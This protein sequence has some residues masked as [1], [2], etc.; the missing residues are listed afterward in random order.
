MSDRPKAGS[1]FNQAILKAWV[2]GVGRMALWATWRAG[3]PT[4]KSGGTGDAPPPPT[5]G[6]KKTHRHQALP[7]SSRETHRHQALAASSSK[8]HRFSRT[9][10]VQ[11]AAH[12][13]D[14]ITHALDALLRPIC[15]ISSYICT[16]NAPS[17][18][19]ENPAAEP[20]T[21]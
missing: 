1:A 4:R 3:D 17:A 5:T 2:A 11:I 21:R 9:P 6:S 7:A 13:T 8:T 16:N 10:P 15:S 12:Q 19:R 18:R 20:N 14:S